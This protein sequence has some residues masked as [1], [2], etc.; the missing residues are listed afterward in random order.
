MKKK[1]KIKSLEET[2]YVIWKREQAL[3]VSLTNLV[4]L[5]LSLSSHS[6]HT[7][8]KEL[9][10]TGTFHIAQDILK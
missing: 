9:S 5:I 6:P 1:D 10:N 3:K 7:S 4:N 8:I 2:N